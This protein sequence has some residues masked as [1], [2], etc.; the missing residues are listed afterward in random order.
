MTL[1]NHILIEERTC[2]LKIELNKQEFIH[3]KTLKYALSIS[4][5]QFFKIIKVFDV[6][7]TNLKVRL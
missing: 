3:L 4:T 7:M 1:F 2:S 5:Q 6:K